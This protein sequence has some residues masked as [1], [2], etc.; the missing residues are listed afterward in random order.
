MAKGRRGFGTIERLPSGQYRAY[1]RDPLGRL[2]A[3]SGT[4]PQ[5]GEQRTRPL[6][7]YATQTFSAKVDAEGWLAAEKRLIDREDWTDPAERRRAALVAAASKLP[8]FETYATKWIRDRR[9]KGRPLAD[10]TKANNLDYL[11]RFLAPTFGEM[12]LDEITPTMVD[13]WY[14]RLCPD[15]PTQRSK[16]YSF[17]R[18]VMNT[19]V[20]SRG[21]MPG[22]SNPFSIRG[23]GATDHRRRDEHVF[24]SA[25]TAAMLAHIREDRRAMIL[26]ALWCGLR[27]GEIVA[28]RR[29]D[30]DMQK[31]IVKVRHSIA[32]PPG[33]VP[34][35]KSPKSAAGNRDA[36]IPAS[37]LPEL[38]RHLSTYMTG[39]DGLLFPSASGDYL[40]PSAFY[41]KPSGLGWYGALGAAGRWEE[42]ETKRPHFHDLRATGATLVARRTRNVIEV[43]RW[44]GDSTP[45]AAMRYMRATDGAMDEIADALSEIAEAGTW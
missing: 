38:K 10:R 3:T 40:R 42:D 44:L 4:D 45:Q 36:R 41:G 9:V 14:D 23:A 6:R 33:V 28:L 8:T 16:V 13:D 35:E 17:A 29:P 1:Y 31:R 37:I 18:A 27:Y 30:I 21:P 12:H 24:T 15:H 43:Q 26:L 20:A 2:V 5:T 19:A 32:F 11:R 7:H 25:E 22:A 39:R 34:V